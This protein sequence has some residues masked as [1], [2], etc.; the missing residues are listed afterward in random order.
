[1]ARNKPILPSQIPI[2]VADN[3]IKRFNEIFKKR[4]Y[5]ELKSKNKI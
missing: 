3:W 4:H 1:M 5:G 2:E